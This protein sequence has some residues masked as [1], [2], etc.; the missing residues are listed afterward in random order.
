MKQLFFLFFLF[1]N[2]HF[3]N[4]Q[5]VGVGTTSPNAKIEVS[6][7]SASPSIPGTNTSTSI[8]R[9]SVSNFEGVDVGKSSIA[10]YSGW[11]QAGYNGTADP[12][13]LQPLGG[14]IGIGT[15]APS[16]SAVLD[17]N[18]TTQ[19]FLPP[20]LTISQ[21]NSIINPSIGLV[22]FC[23]ECDELEVYNGTIWKSMMGTAACVSASLP[24]VKICNQ[25]WMTKNLD[26][27][28]YRNGDNIPQVTDPSVWAS[29]TI[30]AW[31]WYNNDSATYASTYGKL[32]NWHAVNDPRGLSPQG[33]H[34]PSEAE[35]STLSTCLGGDE[36]AGGKMKEAGTTH[37]IS[38]NTG[39]D[40]SSGFAGL[41]GAFRQ[42]NGSFSDIYNYG[43]WWSITE[44]DT[45]F[46]W[47][48]YLSYNN[49]NLFSY[50]NLKSTGFSVRCVRD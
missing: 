6:G 14:N 42:A 46:T 32:Y 7:T 47:F 48:R 36:V 29:L 12:I 24:S 1:L 13:S 21:R 9:V 25:I 40:N 30:G 16:T 39:A 34:I 15:T 11:I 27:N 19:G 31:C 37:W 41:P 3:S 44:F 28:K 33:W 35:W 20:R 43:H 23:T 10:P 5:N 2:L 17:I 26:V 50:Y 18:S 45:T 8:L 4:A 38:P 49:A 22:I